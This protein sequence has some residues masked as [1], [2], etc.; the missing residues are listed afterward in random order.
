MN[1]LT[2]HYKSYFVHYGGVGKEDETNTMDQL[3]NRISEFLQKHKELEEEKI[4]LQQLIN[5]CNDTV[6]D[7][8]KQISTLEQANE[9]YVNNN[10]LLEENIV[11]IQ[12]E[13]TQLTDEN[14]SQKN[15]LDKIN[16]T[17]IAH[18]KN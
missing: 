2:Q 5:E 8:K 15:V 14:T 10:T 9:E 17:L 11:A 13:N 7:L 6:N 12:K 1:K 4:S 18:F 3:R 16:D